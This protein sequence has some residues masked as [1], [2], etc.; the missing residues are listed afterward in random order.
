MSGG[1]RPSISGVAVVCCVH[2]RAKRVVTDPEYAASL[3]RVSGQTFNARRHK[4]HLC[5]C[6]ENLFVTND[7]I[8]RLCDPCSGNPEHKL[9]A[10]LPDP[11]GAIE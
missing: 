8:P 7:D 6:C 3:G 9:E 1:F 4:L 2:D 5:A 11:I 10:P